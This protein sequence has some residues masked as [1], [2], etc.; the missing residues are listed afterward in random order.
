MTIFQILYVRGHSS[1]LIVQMCVWR[2]Q[3]EV[4]ICKQVVQKGDTIKCTHVLLVHIH[5]QTKKTQCKQ[6]WCDSKTGFSC[7]TLCWLHVFQQMLF[8]NIKSSVCINMLNLSCKGATLHK[9]NKEQ[10]GWLMCWIIWLNFPMVE[11]LVH[12]QPM[13]SVTCNVIFWTT[14]T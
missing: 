4:L 2:A 7:T 6:I 1:T 8:Q 14:Y 12:I 9:M 10:T 3:K 13:V 11:F 5:Q